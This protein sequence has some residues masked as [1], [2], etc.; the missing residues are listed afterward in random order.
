ERVQAALA[1]R[2]RTLPPDR[3]AIANALDNLG[4]VLY[5]RGDLPAARKTIEEAL[6]IRRKAL[7]PDHPHTANSVNN[8]GNVLRDLGD[9]AAARMCYEEAV[10]IKRRHL[11]R[12]AAAQGE[13]LQLD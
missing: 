11:D 2:R 8:L 12:T 4:G 13:R 5:D 3:P 1:M 10:A 7:P 6:A 9:L